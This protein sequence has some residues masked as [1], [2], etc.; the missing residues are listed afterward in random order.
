MNY[1]S[2]HNFNVRSTLDASEKAIKHGSYQKAIDIL[3]ANASDIISG[4][5]LWSSLFTLKRSRALM[6]MGDTQGAEFYLAS[7]SEN[8]RKNNPQ[9]DFNCHV[10]EGFL[11][12]RRGFSFSKIGN[13]EAALD[14]YSKAI[15][16]FSLGRFA[17]YCHDNS[18]GVNQCSQNIAYTNGLKRRLS[19]ATHDEYIECIKAIIDSQNFINDELS[20]KNNGA[21]IALV[22]VADLAKHGFVSPNGVLVAL[23]GGKYKA[24]N[25]FGI[26]KQDTWPSII[27][28]FVLKNETQQLDR[29]NAL[30]F[31]AGMLIS[32]FKIGDKTN[33]SIV[34]KY[35][36]HLMDSALTMDTASEFKDL[37]K[38]AKKMVSDLA[39]ITNHEPI[40]RR[41]FR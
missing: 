15:D 4:D 40:T 7:V 41:H 6:K 31:G 33:A 20:K 32:E 34:Y 28:N 36:L 27:L 18:I 8:I 38:K 30:V 26:N 19:N 16:N 9:I 39:Q 24:E 29:H 2:G 5:E 37:P 35:L 21:I 11:D 23:D 14:C 22:M 10:I 12:K 1:Q 17:A 13:N 25:D 3:D